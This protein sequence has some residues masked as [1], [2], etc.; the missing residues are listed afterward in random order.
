TIVTGTLMQG[1]LN[2]GD[3]VK[4][5]PSGRAVRIRSLQSFGKPQQSVAGGARV[6]ANL[7]GVDV[8]EIARGEVLVA[9][10]LAAAQTFAVQF[11]PLTEALP[12]LRRRNPIRAYI[13]SAEILGTLVLGEEPRENASVGGTLFLRRATVAYPGTAFV[14]RRLSPKN[15]LG[16][17]RIESGAAAAEKSVAKSHDELA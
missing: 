9:S 16:G 2:V 6:A 3:R 12:I 17:G 7:P 15:L 5:E 11:T 1:T 10:E 4:L 14:V 8:S 13:G